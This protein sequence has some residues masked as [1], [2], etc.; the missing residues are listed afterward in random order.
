MSDYRRA[1]VPGGTF[2]LTIVTYQRTSLFGVDENVCLLRRALAQV[3]REMPFRL[4]AAVVLPDHL[5]FLWCLPS[6]DTA[7]SARVGRMKII[8]TRLLRGCLTTPSGVSFSRSKHR[9]SNVWQR[10]FWEHAIKDEEDF[11]KHLDYIHYNPVRHGLAACPHSWKYSS[12]PKWVRSGLYPER[13]GCCCEGRRPITPD[14]DMMFDVAG[15]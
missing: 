3:M 9:E 13:W 5:H 12:F 15:E 2:F 7:F 11:E 4:P 14:V 10:R 1:H 6:G 8:F